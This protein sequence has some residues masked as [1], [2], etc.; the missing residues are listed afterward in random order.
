METWFFVT[1]LEVFLIDICGLCS[2]SAIVFRWVVW[3]L[4]NN[5]GLYPEFYTLHFSVLLIVWLRVSKRTQRIGFQCFAED[6]PTAGVGIPIAYSPVRRRLAHPELWKRS[7]L[8]NHTFMGGD[9]VQF[10][11]IQSK[12]NISKTA[13]HIKSI[14]SST[15]GKRRNTYF[16]F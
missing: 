13:A 2:T 16:W 12:T 6:T 15:A 4:W 10:L 11:W 9:D 5:N 8:G 7:Q 3:V 14:Q 1:F